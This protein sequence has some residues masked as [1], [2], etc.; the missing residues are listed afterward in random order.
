MPR[1]GGR[2]SILDGEC[3]T[4]DMFH[5][6]RRG[7]SMPRAVV[8][9]YKKVLNFAPASRGTAKQDF[10]IVLGADSLAAG[11]TSPTDAAVPT[12]AII[13][14]ILFQSVFNNLAAAS[15]FINWSVQRLV[16]GQAATVTPNVVGGD[17][18]RN[19]VMHLDLLSAGQ[20]QNLKHTYLFKVP[21]GMQRVREGDQ[22][23]VTYISTANTEHSMQVIYKFFR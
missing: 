10:Q 13:T 6:R 8:Q 1:T 20:G 14:S 5:R 22:W 7:R 9:S 3:T 4:M 15:D 17:D 18:Q 11:Q 2:K 21:K 19:Q 12:G 16:S 23:F